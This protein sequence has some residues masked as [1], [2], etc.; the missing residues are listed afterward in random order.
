L[1]EPQKHI[2]QDAKLMISQLH[3]VSELATLERAAMLEGGGARAERRRASPSSTSASVGPPLTRTRRLVTALA[4]TAVAALLS[5]DQ[6]LMS[7]NLSAIAADLGLPPGDRDRL[8]GGVVAA[9]FFAVG[10]P[11]A[12][13]AGYACAQCDR[14]RLLALL[15]LLGEAPCLATAWVRTYP[16]LL[17]T[18]LLTGIS[19]GG[20]PPLLYSLVGD[21]A[22]PEQRAAAAAGVQLAVSGGASAGQLLAGVMGSRWGW[23]WPF[24]VV[25]V[26]ALLGAAVMVAVVEDPRPRGHNV[27]P[28]G[29]DAAPGLAPDP[30]SPTTSPS[31]QTCLSLGATVPLP[32]SSPPPSFTGR[33]LAP[34][35]RAASVMRPL[36]AAACILQGLPG[37]LPWGVMGV[38]MADYLAADGGLTVPAAS[39]VLAA[40][41][42]GGGVGVVVGGVAGQAL[43]TGGWARRRRGKGSTPGG[44]QARTCF[45]PG[46]MPAAVG[47]AVALATAPALFLV[48][49]DLKRTPLPAM[50]AIAACGGALACAAG[51]AVRAVL[52]N[53]TPP[54]D[55]GVALALQTVTDDLGRGA[56]P[57]FVAR[58]A[59]GVGRRAAF[60]AAVWAWAPCGALI[61][62][63]GWSLA[64]DVVVEWGVGGEAAG[65]P[66]ELE[67]GNK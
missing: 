9:L 21:L 3:S 25:A 55:R 40:W 19:A 11:A 37:C 43:H 8:L 20:L 54:P 38:Y 5:A 31:S 62:A 35:K 18:R 4:V 48:L 53:V 33:C 66:T 14:V 51:P 44:G 49:G 15:V 22:G 41:G 56:G 24:V 2:Q 52:L 10:A 6:N 28:Q 36:S 32:A 57:F 23:R 17:A 45:G 13:A 46:A 63:A 27:R 61:A 16:A 58:M 30:P 67:E 50:L 7:P 59:G 39:A 60:A 26:P 1:V 34:L 65:S 47:C 12:L 29:M 64:G 42:V